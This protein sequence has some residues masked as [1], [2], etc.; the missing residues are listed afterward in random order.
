[1][2]A[3]PSEKR[4]IEMSPVPPIAFAASSK[5]TSWEKSSNGPTSTLTWRRPLRSW[6]RLAASAR[7]AAAKAPGG[8]GASTSQSPATRSIASSSA[9]RIRWRSPPSSLVASTSRALSSAASRRARSRIRVACP[10]APTFSSS[11]WRPRIVRLRSSSSAR[12][13]AVSSSL[14]RRSISRSCSET[15]SPSARASPPRRSDLRLGGPQRLTAHAELGLEPVDCL[16][17]RAPAVAEQRPAESS[18]GDVRER[19]GGRGREK[20]L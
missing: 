14:R 11:S 17:D 12:S 6:A 20:P 2:R 13:R 1:M 4:L 19:R 10:R 5:R 9:S 3:R 7:A 18:S 16:V 8:V 15:R